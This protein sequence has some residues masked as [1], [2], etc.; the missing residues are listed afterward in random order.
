[1]LSR[2]K[3]RQRE[4]EDEESI[5]IDKGCFDDE[6]NRLENAAGTLYDSREPPLKNKIEKSLPSEHD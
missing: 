4:T 5:E 3:D 2:S 1:L 6:G